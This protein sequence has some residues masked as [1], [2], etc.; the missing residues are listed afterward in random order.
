[1]ALLILDTAYDKVTIPTAL[2]RNVK[3]VTFVGAS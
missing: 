2:P 1:M 3:V